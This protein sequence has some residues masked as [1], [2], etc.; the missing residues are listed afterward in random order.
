MCRQCC[1]FG[2]GTFQKLGSKV[3]VVELLDD[4]LP[5]QDPE[6]VRPVKKKFK[7]AGGAL[8]LKSK[9][10]G[11]SERGGKA[12]LSVEGPDGK[13]FRTEAAKTRAKQVVRHA[14][15]GVL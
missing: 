12:V 4:I 11:L 5:G 9:V 2:E 6:L 8:H 7:A 1:G 13:T 10:S 3:T 15:E 14:T